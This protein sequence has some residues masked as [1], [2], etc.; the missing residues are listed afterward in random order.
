MAE[1]RC[2]ATWPHVFRKVSNASE[3]HGESY[4]K[5]RGQTFTDQQ[6]E[7]EAGRWTDAGTQSRK[8]KRND[9]KGLG[10]P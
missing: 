9:G 10:Q 8:G 7:E 4:G 3:K 1:T 6:Q 5:R 2:Y